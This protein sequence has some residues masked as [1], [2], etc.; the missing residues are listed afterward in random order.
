MRLLHRREAKKGVYKKNQPSSWRKAK[1]DAIVWS[2]RNV[3]R[4][5]LLC[6]SIHT[7]RL[8]HNLNLSN[9]NNSRKLQC[10]N[11]LQLL[12]TLHRRHPF[13]PH[14]PVHH[15]L[16]STWDSPLTLL[17]RNSL[18]LLSSKVIHLSLLQCHR[19]QVLHN[20]PILQ[21]YVHRITMHTGLKR[22][23][24]RLPLGNTTTLCPS[25]NLNSSSSNSI[26]RNLHY[27]NIS[28]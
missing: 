16:S 14:H 21:L 11:K 22:P 23:L 5:H 26:R 3:Q 27:L 7:F 15:H 4:R 12:L 2:K 28:L 6:G 17:H 8:H 1:M 24:H 25:S 10:R 19:R 13:R 18:L 20:L 9:S